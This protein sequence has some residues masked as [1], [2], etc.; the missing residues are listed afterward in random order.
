MSLFR[1]R[2]RK[3]FGGTAAAL[4]VAVVA[5]GVAVAYYGGSGTG[6]A[7]ASLGHSPEAVTVTAD[8]VTPTLYPGDSSDPFN[9]YVQTGPNRAAHV[10]SIDLDPAFGGGS[11]ITGLPVG[12]DPSWFTLNPGTGYPFTIPGGTTHTFPGFQLT[13]VESGTSQDACSDGTPVVHLLA[14]PTP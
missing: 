7:S 1:S 4:I 6:T 9:I 14:S 13:F 5:V 12:C 8:P 11:G 3:V 10:G 2:R